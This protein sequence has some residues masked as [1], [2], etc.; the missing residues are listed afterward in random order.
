MV[1]AL[2]AARKASRLPSRWPTLHLAVLILKLLFE[3][4]LEPH[5]LTTFAAQ[6]AP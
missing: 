1:F 2:I 6:S 5:S 4:R 3:S